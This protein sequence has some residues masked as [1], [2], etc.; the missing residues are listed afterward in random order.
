MT[1]TNI[2][3]ATLAAIGAIALMGSAVPALAGAPRTVDQAASLTDWQQSVE[4]AIDREMRPVKDMNDNEFRT[5]RL[6]ID[7]DAAGM[8]TGSHIVKGSGRYGTDQ[9][10]RR[11]ARTIAYPRL[12]VL[13]QGKPATIVMELY[14][15][16][17]QTLQMAQDAT[18]ASHARTSATIARMESTVRQ[19]G[20]AAGQPAG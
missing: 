7:F 12:P 9:E 5:V 4:H 15:A 3:T 11:V 13:M 10:A 14:F 6:G 19:A 16:T 1:H 17:P 2:R 18:A 20:N 8:V